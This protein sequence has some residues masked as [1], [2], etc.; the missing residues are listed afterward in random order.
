MVRNWKFHAVA[1]S[2][3]CAVIT[4]A[5]FLFT[6]APPPPAADPNTVGDRA[7]EI[8]SATW[9]M[10]C[11]PY[12]KEQIDN[13][14]AQPLPKAGETADGHTQQQ[15]VTRDNALMKVGELCN[16]KNTCTLMPTNETLGLSVL[17]SC[18]KKLEI[19]YRCY[20]YDRLWPLTIG[21]GETKKI[22][23]NEAPST[24]GK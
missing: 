9:G 2:T 1:L 20:S 8:Y 16:A 5:Y 22:D 4:G 21:Q 6:P 13:Q 18:G 23:C 11:N 10:E 17:N 14:K 19:T 12:I 7:I 3:I 24:P 15:L